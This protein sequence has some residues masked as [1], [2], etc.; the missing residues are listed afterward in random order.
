MDKPASTRSRPAPAVGVE[1]ILDRFAT[2][3]AET[4]R[5]TAP[6]SAED[7]VVQSMP[8][9][10]PAK[11]HLA[12]TSWFFE[13]FVLLPHAPGYT[14]YSEELQFLFN[15]Y[16]EALGERRE[17]GARGLVTRPG[18]EEVLA[19]RRHVNTAVLA[20]GARAQG[21]VESIIEVGL[22]HEEQ[23]GE[24]ILTDVLHLFAQTPR[25][26]AY[27]DL[28]LPPSRSP[29]EMGKLAFEG[30]LVEI[31]RDAEASSFGFDNEGPRHRV[32]LQPFRLA[33]RLVTNAEWL[34]FMDGGGY[35]RAEL[36]LADGWA[37]VQA[38]G[39]KAPLYWEAIDGAW[40][41]MTL[42][43]LRPLDLLAPVVHVSL[44]EADAYARWAGARL[45]TEAEWEHAA[46]DIPV[47]GNLRDSGWL[48]PA[49]AGGPKGRLRQM[50]GDVWEWTASAY[51][52]YPGFKPAAGAVGEYNGKFMVSQA[53]LRGG[54]CL[55][56]ARHIRPT[57]RNFFQPWHRWQFTGVRLAWDAEPRVISLDSS[58]QQRDA[59]LADVVDGLSKAQKTLSSKWLYD[60]EGSRLFEAITELPEYYPTRTELAILRE[61][62]PDI[63]AEIDPGAA[64]VEFGSGA[65]VKTRIVLNAAPQLA[66]YVPVDISLERLQAAAAEIRR[67]YP[68]LRVEPLAGDFT[69]GLHLPE[70]AAGRP[71]TG[72]FPGS[73]IGNFT[74]EGAVGFL[75]SAASVLGEGAYLLVGIDLVKPEPVLLAAYDDAQG[76]TAEFNRNLLARANR[77]LGADFD[78]EGFA[79]RAVWNPAL[80]RIEMHLESLRPQTVR[81]DGRVYRF[82][83]GET[84]HT[85]NSH[86]FTVDGFSGLAA[87]AGWRQDRVW[88]DA[89]RLF[90]VVLLKR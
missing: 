69:A 58:H 53:V 11:W 64:L 76:V 85:E 16:Y 3:R 17:R 30:G 36:W 52:P 45:P 59:F 40:F 77:E 22:A 41:V 75:R 7:Q 8:D 25:R 89:G 10:S 14:A 79:H 34:Q 80:R 46:G 71:R 20:L 55:T 49:A 12:H 38:E 13:T 31:G 32:L 48:Q 28:P 73:T 39:W 15:S 67:D 62:A 87:R 9:A 43:G 84:L 83:K 86:K 56:P 51:A 35:G 57:Y 66:V 26:P 54:S 23:H 37:R 4:L 81:M 60:E 78:L 70:A 44:Y 63:A 65:S 21:R 6:L 90:A 50:F 19:Y 1:S 5:L 47:E 18:L 82:E 42:S 2:V 88:T 68:H 61:A 24:L 27:A 72:F 29:G 33:D 74:E